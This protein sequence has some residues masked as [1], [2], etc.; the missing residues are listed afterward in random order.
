MPKLFRI[1]TQVLSTL[2]GITPNLP[3]SRWQFALMICIATAA[4]CPTAN[5]QVQGSK[6]ALKQASPESVASETAKIELDVT[7]R[8]NIGGSSEL[9]R[10][11]YFNI[12]GSPGE[13]SNEELEWLVGELRAN[14]GRSMGTISS[15][16]HGLK[17]DPNRPGFAD[18]NHLENRAQEFAKRLRTQYQR[19]G[20]LVKLVNSVHPYSYYGKEH[21]PDDGKERFTPGSHEAAAE[22]LSAF[23]RAVPVEKEPYFEVANEC[24]VHAKKLGT[25][26]ADMCDLHA[27]LAR[28]LHK[29]AP[30]LQIGGP[31][32]AWPA[33]EVKDFGIWREQMG[34]FIERAAAEMD[35]LSMHLYTT[36]WDNT[37]KNRF[38]ANI[39]AILDL[40]ETQSLL[41][42]G[43]VKPLLISECGTG[44]KTGEQIAEEY[45]PYRDW[46][47]LRGA[48]HVMMNLVRRDDRVI[49]MVP[50]ITAKATWY[51][52][53]HPYPWVL[54]HKQNGQ[55]VPTHLAKWY[56]FWKEVQGQHLPTKC[57]S[58][59]VQTHAVLDNDTVYLMIDN[60]RD[61][62]VELELQESIPNT[63]SIANV[64]ISRLFFDGKQPVYEVQE[65][66]EADWRCLALKP[67]EAAIVKLKLKAAPFLDETLTESTHYADRTLRPIDKKAT[68]FK[69]D[70]PSDTNSL[71]SAMLRVSF[72]R[73]KSLSI[74]PRVT[75]N[76][77]ELHVPENERG[78]RDQMGDERFTAKEIEVPTEILKKNNRIAVQF[79]DS[80]GHVSSVVL[81]AREAVSSANPGVAAIEPV[82]AR[83]R[84][85][86]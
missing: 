33:F 48:N 73:K 70:Y 47:I 79:P 41:T 28:Q 42:T 29:D 21:A 39:D 84:T 9:R 81:V 27:R 60:L 30:G 20:G 78:Q 71:S 56:D 85:R 43:Q 31:T 37:I 4:C 59:D 67:H 1:R 63:S 76:G 69:V 6:Q 22:I 32:A 44:L 62:S 35:F 64:A 50:F 54:F 68:Y 65:S 82:R 58:L 8:L 66:V 61:D 49:K 72:G 74:Q 53:D 46:L 3:D 17:E 13:F 16:I 52:A 10:E 2:R 34:M 14:F 40:L 45:S 5:S 51:K 77:T 36:H 18:K 55:W 12:H 26:F 23:Y 80:G 57:S 25:T 24:N 38:G 83:S 7:R 19:H 11:A 75:L 86:E 15:F